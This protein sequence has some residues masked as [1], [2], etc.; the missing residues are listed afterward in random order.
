M[1]IHKAAQLSLGGGL[2]VYGLAAGG[3]MALPSAIIMVWALVTGVL[4]IGRAINA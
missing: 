2:V 4:Y 1:S 3:L